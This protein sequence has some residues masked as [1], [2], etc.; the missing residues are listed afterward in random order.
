VMK[1]IEMC[2]DKP[3]KCYGR[4]STFQTFTGDA[5]QENIHDP[6]PGEDRSNA[7]P[8]M[9]Y[10]PEDVIKGVQ[11]WYD[12]GATGV[13]LFNQSDAWTT[14]RHLPYPE[15]LRQDQAAG[16]T[17]GKHEGPAVEWE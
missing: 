13:F 8:L 5:L 12:A 4:Y 15:L 14:L 17:F 1:Y 16:V 3:T 10:G 6:T 9:S 11:Q 2:K 7:P